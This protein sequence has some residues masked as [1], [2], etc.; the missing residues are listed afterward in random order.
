MIAISDIDIDYNENADSIVPDPH[1]PLPD[2]MWSILTDAGDA[3]V[4]VKPWH[5]MMGELSTLVQC[6]DVR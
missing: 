4:S 5:W 2:G 1:R 6:V 3:I